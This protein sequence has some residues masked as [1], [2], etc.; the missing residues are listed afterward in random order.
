[1]W[2]IGGM[3]FQALEMSVTIETW[4]LTTEF[5]PDKVM[6][7]PLYVSK[8]KNI[9]KT[10]IPTWQLSLKKKKKKIQHIFLL[11][12]KQVQTLRVLWSE[13]SNVSHF[14]IYDLFTRI[15]RNC[16]PIKID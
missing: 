14:I 9:L 13:F 11:E 8:H 10:N 3:S 2:Y 12:N 5:Q 4:I 15:D 7:L 16:Q 6:I 1:M